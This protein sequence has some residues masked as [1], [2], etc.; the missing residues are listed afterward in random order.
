MQHANL[1]WHTSASFRV[2]ISYA[3]AS[4][5]WWWPL[6]VVVVALALWWKGSTK[7]KK[8]H[9]QRN[10][11]KWWSCVLFV[12]ANAVTQRGCM[13]T[14]DEQFS[15]QVQQSTQHAASARPA[16]RRL[17]PMLL[18]PSLVGRDL[19]GLL[20]HVKGGHAHRG[21][22]STD[23]RCAAFAVAF[24][25]PTPEKRQLRKWALS[26]LNFPGCLNSNCCNLFRNSSLNW[27]DSTLSCNSTLLPRTRLL[28]C[29]S[30][31]AL[32]RLHSHWRVIVSHSTC[33]KDVVVMAGSVFGSVSG[34][35]LPVPLVGLQ[36]LPLAA[37]CWFIVF[38]SCS[39]S[40]SARSGS[41]NLP[42]LSCVLGINKKR[43]KTWT[44]IK[45]K[46]N[47][48]YK[49]HVNTNPEQTHISFR[50]IQ[51]T[52]NKYQK[53]CSNPLLS[54]VLLTI[55]CFWK[56]DTL[57][58]G[59]YCFSYL[60]IGLSAAPSCFMCVHVHNRPRSRT[61]HTVKTWNTRDCVFN[62][63]FLFPDI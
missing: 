58:N 46:K 3:R 11:K 23:L 6:V 45:L 53:N 49:K 47:N 12:F 13:W 34:T 14:V 38:H 35:S 19:V 41:L 55:W 54:F 21:E 63:F 59:F 18:A 57:V 61:M 44:K 60:L 43:T 30:I 39:H 1:H 24:L 16:S 40:F 7:R 22:S 29:S 25:I 8:K 36:L 33:G 27:L 31:G 52:P 42:C 37:A 28:Q 9:K 15:V 5:W 17:R 48:K 62:L 32:A 4:S 51:E 26:R 10:K 56:S 50:K 2:A 20:R